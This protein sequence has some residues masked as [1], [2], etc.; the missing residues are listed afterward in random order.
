[1]F[2]YYFEEIDIFY[3]NLNLAWEIH[4]R[5]WGCLA[6]DE[7]L[8]VREGYIVIRCSTMGQQHVSNIALTMKGHMPTLWSTMTRI[9]SMIYLAVKMATTALFLVTCFMS[10]SY[11]RFVL[12]ICKNNFTS[13]V[14]PMLIVASYGPRFFS[15]VS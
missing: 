6:S 5:Q 10:S 13:Y 8:V 7:F 11:E 14:R 12:F 9:V 15:T 3:F 4:T 1:M 2:F